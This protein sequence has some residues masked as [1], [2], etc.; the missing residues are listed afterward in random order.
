[1][2]ATCELYYLSHTSSA[3]PKILNDFF[4]YRELTLRRRETQLKSRE[5]QVLWSFDISK[6]DFQLYNIAT[7]DF[8]Q[9]FV[10]T[11]ICDIQ[12]FW[13]YDAKISGIEE[14]IKGLRWEGG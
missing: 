6:L 4:I 7:Q 14:V 11:G 3:D 10:V 8:F 1:V 12:G 5:L 2:L 9:E 13:D